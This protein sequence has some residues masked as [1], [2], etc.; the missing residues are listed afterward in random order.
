MMQ[1]VGQTHTHT[2]TGGGNHK[3]WEHEGSGN[4]D[5]VWSVIGRVAI[6]NS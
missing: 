6:D 4:F 5:D 2:H 3:N 1:R